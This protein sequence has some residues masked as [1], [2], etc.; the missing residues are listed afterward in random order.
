MR[1][2]RTI[3]SS[4]GKSPERGSSEQKNRSRAIDLLILLALEV[5]DRE[6]SRATVSS[7]TGPPPVYHVAAEQKHSVVSRV[8]QPR[9]K[10]EIKD[11]RWRL[12]IV[13]QA[14]LQ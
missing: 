5:K 3:E 6:S 11:W 12:R 13:S 8:A 1:R 7:R 14:V 4:C 10:K 2:C 9:K